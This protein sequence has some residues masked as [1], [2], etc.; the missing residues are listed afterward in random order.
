MNEYAELNTSQH[1]KNMK[2]KNKTHRDNAF[3]QG[4]LA[5]MMRNYKSIKNQAAL[6][7][8][9]R[10]RS[11]PLCGIFF[12]HKQ[13]QFSFRRMSWRLDIFKRLSEYYIV[14]NHKPRR[15][16]GWEAYRKDQNR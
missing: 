13:F 16:R 5:E 10:K 2:L 4:R 3:I 12:E 11:S 9:E 6:L 15:L 14:K 1:S 7:L 8:K